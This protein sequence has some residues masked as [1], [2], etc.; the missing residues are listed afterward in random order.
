LPIVPAT[1]QSSSKPA[2]T[3]ASPPPHSARCTRESGCPDSRR[4]SRPTR[5]VRAYAK[6]RPLSG[7][8]VPLRLWPLSQFSEQRPPSDPLLPLMVGP[9]NGRKREKAVFG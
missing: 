5:K 9:V 4:L 8:S 2:S 3:R 7:A 1:P 6:E